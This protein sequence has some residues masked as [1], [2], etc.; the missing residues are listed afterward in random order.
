MH[1]E[2]RSVIF[3]A[4]FL[5]ASYP[6][7]PSYQLMMDATETVAELLRSGAGKFESCADWISDFNVGTGQLC[8]HLKIS[9][10]NIFSYCLFKE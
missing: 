6:G 3:E 1:L 9:G 8:S 4:I 5:L 10:E 2:R 7:E